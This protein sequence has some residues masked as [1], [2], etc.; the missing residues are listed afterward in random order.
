MV[1]LAK[2]KFIPEDLIQFIIIVLSGMNNNLIEMLVK[3]GHG[4]RQPDNLGTGADD[5]HDFKSGDW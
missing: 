5:G 1:R 4:P 2:L 3:E